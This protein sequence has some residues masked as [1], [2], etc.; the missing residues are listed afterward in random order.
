MIDGELIQPIV[1]KADSEMNSV[2][3]PSPWPGV[4]SGNSEQKAWGRR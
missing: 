3:E 4:E 2:Q 1:L